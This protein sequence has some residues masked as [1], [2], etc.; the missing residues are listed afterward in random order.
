MT[1]HFTRIIAGLGL[2]AIAGTAG[3]TI[4]QIDEFTVTENGE[5]YWLDTFSDGVAPFDRSAQNP[6]SVDQNP[7]NRAYLL[8]SGLSQ[9]PGPEA[10]DMLAMDTAEGRLNIGTVNPVLNRTQR[11]RVNASTNP[12]NSSA[13]IATEAINVTG[14]FELIEP[15][16]NRE[17]YSVR[18]T[19]WTSSSQNEGLELAVQKNATGDWRVAFRQ[20]DVGVQWDV[21]EFWDLPGIAGGY[22]QIALSL[23]NDPAVAG[24]AEFI[25][26]FSLFDSD[27]VLA[28][29]TFTSSTPGLMFQVSDWLRP[30]FTARRRVPEPPIVALLALGLAVIGHQRR[31]PRE[32]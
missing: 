25:A 15:E 19:D 23:F 20:A 5:T 28:D 10:G 16:R 11:A 32:A 22:E 17:L 3:G 8:P 29:Q 26:Q 24:G 2:C 13:L 7:Y 14:I 18:L 6:A 9:L 27:A 21:I 31:K 30:E 4:F 12:N 1:R